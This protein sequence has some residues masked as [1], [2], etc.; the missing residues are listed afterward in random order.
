M[1]QGGR[2]RELLTV[3]Q[4]QADLA[5]LV[6]AD[7]RTE[8]VPLTAAGGRVLAVAAHAATSLPPFDNSS[9]DGYA[10]RFA[11]VATVPVALAVAGESR[12]G[13]REAPDAGPGECVRIMTGAPLPGWADAVVPVEDTDEGPDRV[14]VRVAPTGPGAF[15][16]RAGEDVGPGALV[17]DAG[18]TL[19]GGLIGAL[20]AAGIDPVA[21]RPR[22]VVALCATGDELAAPGAELAYGQI[23]DANTPALAARLAQAGAEVVAAEPVGD[24]PRALTLWLDAVAPSSA[25]IVLTGGASVGAYD[26]VRDVLQGAGGTFRHV[27]VQPGKPQGWA[28]W[29]GTPVVALPGN[30]V[31]AA[32]S[33]ELFVRPLLDRI[34][35]RPEPP[36]FTAVAAV[37]WSS[38]V[39]R[40]QLVPVRLV[41]GPDGRLLATPAHPRG[42]ASHLVT[43]L[44][45][46]DGYVAVPEDATAVAPGD[47][48]PLRLL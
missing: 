22:P 39:G 5:A 14:E 37:G 31:S 47:L 40:R 1:E 42:S 2:V 35:G 23:H 9:M 43:A 25:L 7:V 44:A 30:P 18:A 34:L 10:V 11:D 21:V 3:E 20:A 24:D 12:A 46:A 15:V 13:D 8:D 36:W 41:G 26:V 45:H 48:L 4:Y 33:C 16:R 38:P 27:R 32:L 19:T 29:R 6:G 28:R 17:A